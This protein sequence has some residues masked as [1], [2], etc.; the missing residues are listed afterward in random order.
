VIH[1]ICFRYLKR[2]VKILGKSIKHIRTDNE[3]E[4][5]NSYFKQI[6]EKKGIE[7]QKT[8]PYNSE[9]NGKVE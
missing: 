6:T 9:S 5:V 3:T 2:N 8:V 7:H 1:F 4:F